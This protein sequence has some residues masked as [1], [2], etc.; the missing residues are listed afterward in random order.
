MA[1]LPLPLIL[2]YLNLVSISLIL[3]LIFV[4]IF[5]MPVVNRFLHQFIVGVLTL[6]LFVRLTAVYVT[7]FLMRS[8]IP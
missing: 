7:T 2:F 8:N 4:M 1:N 3:T 5:R 6:G